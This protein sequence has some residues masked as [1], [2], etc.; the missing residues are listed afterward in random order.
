[1]TKLLFSLAKYKHRQFITNLL[2]SNEAQNVCGKLFDAFGSKNV[3]MYH[4]T[5]RISNRRVQK[6][7]K[8]EEA[9]Q[10]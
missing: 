3:I 4:H 2:Y 5:V 10:I 8:T 9:F 6:R 7:F 1:M